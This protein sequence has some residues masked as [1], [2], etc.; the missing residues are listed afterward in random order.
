MEASEI[1]GGG[2]GMA[3][4]P[5]PPPNRGG[6]GFWNQHI[7]PFS[8]EDREEETPLGYRLKKNTMVRSLCI[9]QPLLTTLQLGSFHQIHLPTASFTCSGRCSCLPGDLDIIGMQPGLKALL[10]SNRKTWPR[11]TS[12]RNTGRTFKADI[13]LSINICST[14]SE[15]F[16]TVPSWRCW[17]NYGNATSARD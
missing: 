5:L 4:G 6:R 12:H 9:M 17:G 10:F 15:D 3:L 16:E 1:N 11:C 2:L 14:S 13:S 7:L 8:P